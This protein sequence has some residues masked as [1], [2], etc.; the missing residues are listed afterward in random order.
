M[1]EELRREVLVDDGLTDRGPVKF[2]GVDVGYIEKIS[3]DKQDPQEV[4]LLIKVDQKAPITTSTT[5]TL[6]QQGITGVTFVGLKAKTPAA[7]PLL[8][9]DGEPYPVIPSEPS[10][11]LQL[12]EALRDVTNGLKTMGDSFK[13]MD[14]SFKKLF[15]SENMASLQNIL[16]RTSTASNQFPDAMEKFRGA[17]IG[18]TSASEQ[19]KTTL[20]NS[21]STIRNLDLALRSLN[22]Q[23]L[24]EIYQ[25]AHTL[26]ETLIDVKAVTSQLKQNPAAI[27]RGTRAV[28]PGPGE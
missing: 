2:N 9:R 18:L 1:L 4:R 27:I 10:L 14:E 28:P 20:Q 22:E 15:T 19:V 12:N 13:G 7:P 17:A 11:L 3:I 24:P 23:T 21:E 8:K 25:A 26:K 5:A 16:A 6:M